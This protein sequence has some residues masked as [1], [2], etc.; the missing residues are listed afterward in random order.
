MNYKYFVGIDV[1]K[2]TLDYSILSE[3]KEILHTQLKNSLPLIKT[4]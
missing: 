1:S 4:E 3:G 2:K